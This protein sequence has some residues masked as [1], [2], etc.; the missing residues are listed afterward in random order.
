[1]L[2]Y[3]PSNYQA[4]SE[5]PALLPI[6]GKNYGGGESLFKTRT[7][8]YF[9]LLNYVHELLKQT[10]LCTRISLRKLVYA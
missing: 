8:F 6:V 2:V 4:S 3:L 7:K 1:M 9:S 10:S 5:G